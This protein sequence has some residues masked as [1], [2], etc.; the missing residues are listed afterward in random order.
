M[1]SNT[2]HRHLVRFLRKLQA[3]NVKAVFIAY[4]PEEARIILSGRIV[5]IY[6]D[7]RMVP[8][9]LP[10]GGL[11]DHVQHDPHARAALYQRIHARDLTWAGV[12]RRHGWKDEARAAVNYATRLRVSGEAA[13]C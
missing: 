3:H 12:C 5:R 1:T 10:Y 9:M 4:K 2:T 6:A 13:S 8:C 7:G 11:E